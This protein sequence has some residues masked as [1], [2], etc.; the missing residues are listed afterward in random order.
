MGAAVHISRWD[1]REEM[2][3]AGRWLGVVA[4]QLGVEKS[5]ALCCR[6]AGEAVYICLPR[7][8]AVGD[9]FW[10]QGFRVPGMACG[11]AVSGLGG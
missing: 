2:R 8:C 9:E 1:M 3:G 10:I 6:W 7:G 4:A 11:K 5:K